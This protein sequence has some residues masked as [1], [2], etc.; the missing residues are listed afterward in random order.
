M[1]CEFVNDASTAH[2][3][4]DSDGGSAV[5]HDKDE[6]DPSSLHHGKDADCAST[7]LNKEDE[8]ALTSPADLADD[9]IMEPVDILGFHEKVPQL[10]VDG[11]SEISLSSRSEGQCTDIIRAG[12]RLHEQQ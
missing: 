6:G 1:S 9:K 5:Y 10:D 3:D 4:M 2:H 11:Y 12:Q 8:T 7:L